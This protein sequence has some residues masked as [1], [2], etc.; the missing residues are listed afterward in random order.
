MD[1][2]MIWNIFHCIARG[3]YAM[4]CGHE[5]LDRERWDRDEIVHFDLKAQ[6]GRS[7]LQAQI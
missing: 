3:L 6:N 4:H 7:R 5:E 1:E 2:Y